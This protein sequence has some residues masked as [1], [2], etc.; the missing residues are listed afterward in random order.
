MKRPE[1]RPI[2]SGELFYNY[3]ST[4]GLYSIIIPLWFRQNSSPRETTC[5]CFIQ[6]QYEFIRRKKKETGN[7]RT[8]ICELIHVMST[9][10]LGGL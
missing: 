8:N 2:T 5:H 1:Q 10:I 6:T 7:G 4:C 9:V 3:L